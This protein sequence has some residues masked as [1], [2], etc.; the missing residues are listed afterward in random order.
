MS[1]INSDRLLATAKRWPT[2][3]DE[4]KCATVRHMPN[5]EYWC[6][7]WYVYHFHGQDCTDQEYEHAR[8][9]WRPLPKHYATTLEQ[10]D[11][12][13]ASRGVRPWEQIKPADEPQQT[14]MDLL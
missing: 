12:R 7:T 5:V 3:S 1:K 9:G 11:A 6:F 13:R 4:E 10:Y 8:K 2:M 14:A